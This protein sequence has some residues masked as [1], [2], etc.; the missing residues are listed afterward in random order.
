MFASSCPL[1]PNNFDKDQIHRI[2]PFQMEELDIA[3]QSMTNLKSADESGIVIEM[4][5]H[6]ANTF[7]ESLISIFNQT[8]MD[9]SFEDS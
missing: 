3:L 7:K 2:P 8:L 5:K 6:A 9:A 4:V 1:I